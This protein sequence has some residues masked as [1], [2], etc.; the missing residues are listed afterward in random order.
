[1]EVVEQ[2]L[3]FL[4]C[5]NF[6]TTVKKSELAQNTEYVTNI[7]LRSN[8]FINETNLRDIAHYIAHVHVNIKPSEINC[9]QHQSFPC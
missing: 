1:M 3:G 7:F 8:V 6:I 4:L 9:K 2:L 5:Q